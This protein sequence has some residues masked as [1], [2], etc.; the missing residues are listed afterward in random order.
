MALAREDESRERET[1]AP[2]SRPEIATDAAVSLG[3]AVDPRRR[4]L[5]RLAAIRALREQ[6]EALEAL[7]VA[8]ALGN[9]RRR[10]ED[11]GEALGMSRSAVHRKHG[12]HGGTPTTEGRSE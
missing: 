12:G 10:L 4:S 1:P 6:L 8:A 7:D 3:L 5:Q 2:R 9:E 11:V